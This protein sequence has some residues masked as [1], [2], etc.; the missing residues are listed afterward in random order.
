LTGIDE[1]RECGVWLRD[2]E[3]GFELL[4]LRQKAQH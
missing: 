2:F 1:F 3:L 4:Q